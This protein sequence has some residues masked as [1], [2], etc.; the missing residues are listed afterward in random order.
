M[1]F[2]GAGAW[3]AAGIKT[4]GDMIWEFKQKLYCSEKKVPLSFI[5]DPGDPIVQRKMQAHF[6]AQGKFPRSG[7]R[8]NTQFILTPPIPLRR[9]GEPTSTVRCRPANRPTAI[10]P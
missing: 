4:A 9:T 5:A 10:S 7:R 1:W 3:R 6:D 2:L 8:A